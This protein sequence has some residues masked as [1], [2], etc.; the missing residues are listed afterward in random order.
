MINQPARA[1]NRRPFS[2]LFV[3]RKRLLHRPGAGHAGSGF[4]CDGIG[5]RF[6]L[7]NP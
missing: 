1:R 4:L 6:E 2:L 3:I 7:V 5:K